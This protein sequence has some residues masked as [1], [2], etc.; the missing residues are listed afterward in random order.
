MRGRITC[1]GDL[2]KPVT[3]RRIPGDGVTGQDTCI[4]SEK[5]VEK[6][7]EVEVK[8]H[9]PLFADEPSALLVPLV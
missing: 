2:Q 4:P 3:G 7:G 1:T 8:C 6:R 5:E 9:R